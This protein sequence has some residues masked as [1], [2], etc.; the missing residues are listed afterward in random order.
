VKQS[1]YVKV[2]GARHTGLGAG[3]FAGSDEI[4][5]AIFRLDFEGIQV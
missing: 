2:N 3:G 4:G 1:Q 5:H